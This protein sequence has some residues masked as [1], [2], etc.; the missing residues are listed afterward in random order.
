MHVVQVG[1]QAMAWEDMCRIIQGEQIWAN[2]CPMGD[3]LVRTYLGY[4]SVFK[5]KFWAYILIKDGLGYSWVIT[6]FTNSYGHPDRP[7]SMRF[8]SV[9]L[10]IEVDALEQ[11]LG[12]RV[13]SCLVSFL[14]PWCFSDTGTV[15]HH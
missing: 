11:D 3:C 5:G 12:S 4:Y 9:Q 8:L 7:D 6:Y 1:P 14:F 13:G 10:S 2:F 15:L